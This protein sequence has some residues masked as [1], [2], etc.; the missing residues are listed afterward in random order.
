MEK[1]LG[2]ILAG[3]HG[4]RMDLLCHLRPKPAL[5]FAG[6]LRVIDFT[7]SNCI[8][9]QI[10]NIAV[11]VDYQRSYMLNYLEEWAAANAGSARI[12][13]LKP[14]S[15][16]YTGT[17]NAVYQNLAYLNNQAG[18]RVVVLA[19]DH[20]YRMD[21]GKMLAFHEQVKADATIGVIRVPIEE[22][23]RFGTMV[24]DSE[25][26]IQEFAEKSSRPLST[27]ASM[28]IYVFNKD[29]LVNRLVEDASIEDSPHDFGYAVLPGMVKRNRVFAYEFSGYWKDIGTVEAYY[30][31]NM[32]LLAARPRFSLDSN[33]PVLR[34][35][36]ALPVPERSK[37]GKVINSL[38]SPSCVVKGRVENSVLSP[39]VHVEEQAIIKNSIVMA[40]TFVGYH[41]VVENCI[42][43]EE[44]RIGRLCYIGFG[45]SRLPG[46]CGDITIL[47]KDVMVPDYT[48]IGPK[49][50]VLPKAELA[51]FAGSLVPTGTVVL[52][53]T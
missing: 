20:V 9:S 7:L 34:D 41:S 16:T 4:R 12:S 37:D 42:L 24:V 17:A 11:M 23:Y 29:I 25:S 36:D 13:V 40:N 48:A 31:A 50:K 3:G 1:T 14:E 21:Y 30:N 44:V 18:N 35:H 45:N 28:G 46:N 5:P 52:P 10:R 19:G 38:I 47:G 32:E 6:K 43:D 8:H 39:G 22:A 33:W 2:I 26:R 49:C 51:A 27:L 15:G 53:V